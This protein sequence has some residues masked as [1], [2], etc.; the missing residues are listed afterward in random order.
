MPEANIES[1]LQ[2]LEAGEAIKTLKARYLA[3]CDNKDPA[4]VRACF[5]DGPVPMDYGP[6]GQFDDADAMVA[7]YADIAC[8][9][10]MVEMHHGVNPQIEIIDDDH[11]HGE[12]DVH[13]QLI[14]TQD[15]TLTQLG[16][17]YWDEYKRTADGWKISA[18]RCDIHFT[19]SIQLGND[20]LKTL[21]A[22]SQPPAAPDSQTD[23]A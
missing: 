8:H 9:D 22:G 15:M 18:S 5:A 19:L 10:Y 4:G 3:C 13:Y 23:S 7:V 1:R 20:A 17:H 6:I 12:W 14:N 21:F 11:A 16:G 2:R